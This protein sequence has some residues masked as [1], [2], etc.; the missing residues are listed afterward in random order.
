MGPEHFPHQS[1]RGR[2]ANNKPAGLGFNST[3]AGLAAVLVRKPYT[4]QGVTS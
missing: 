2:G 3:A 1:Q 4:N